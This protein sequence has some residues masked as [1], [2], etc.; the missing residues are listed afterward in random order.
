[1][2][3][4]GSQLEARGPPLGLG[5]GMGLELHAVALPT[6]LTAVYFLGPHVEGWGSMGKSPAS[7]SSIPG[8]SELPPEDSVLPRAPVMP[9]LICLL[10]SASNTC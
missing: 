6:A 7:P 1:M 8:I 9:A 5:L 3:D 10:T 4:Q 2:E